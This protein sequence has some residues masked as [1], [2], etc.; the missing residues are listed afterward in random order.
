MPVKVPAGWQC[1]DDK[2]GDGVVCDCGCGVLD[3]DCENDNA[4]SCDTCFQAG[5][6]ANWLCPSN[7]VPDD[8]TRCE[9]P[10]AWL[11]SDRY[12][13][14][15]LCDCGCEVIDID[16][17]NETAAVCDRCPILGCGRDFCATLDP[18]DNRLCM[19]APSGWTCNPRLYRDG[20]QCDCGCGYRDP[21]CGF[22]RDD[23]ESCNGEGSCSGL[24]CP[25]MI[26]PDA[27][28][29]CIK[30]PAPDGWLCNES[31]YGDGRVCNCGCGVKDADCRAND[32]ALCDACRCS[33]G[34]CQETLEPTDATQ[35]AWTCGPALY[36]DGGCHCDCG[37]TDP[38][39]VGSEEECLN[40]PAEWTCLD[41]VY[42][43]G[44]CDCGC[45]AR[46]PDC[47]SSDK[48]ACDF[49]DAEGSC[50]N[51]ICADPNSTIQPTDNASCS[52]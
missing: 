5:S 42:A 37:I 39:C 30:P 6:C 7:L 48:S 31:A 1:L 17:E 23:C 16:C 36:R 15:G 20:E 35:C 14:D 28:Q 13:G 24:P 44:V 40:A 50:S 27:I 51:L 33:E 47:S 34:R 3:P 8:N 12:Y 2:Y 9:M 49:C 19:S 38:D 22:D 18:D 26:N 41:E 45:G 21:D 10:D 52:G 43:D 11:C 4:E 25:G 46:D 32:L 29:A